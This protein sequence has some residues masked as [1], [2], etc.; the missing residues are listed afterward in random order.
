MKTSEPLAPTA[1]P[2]RDAA[3][4]RETHL[5][6]LVREHEKALLA[7]TEKLLNDHYL[8]EDI[9]QETLVRAWHNA[10]RL[11][12]SEGSVRGWLLTVARNLV[13]DRSRSGFHR[14]EVTGA[15]MFDV[16]QR[17]HADAVVASVTVAEML[18]SLSAEHRDV[19]VHTYLRGRTIREAADDLGIPV[20]TAKSRQHYALSHL[21]KYA[22]AKWLK[23]R[24]A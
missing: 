9:V 22:R 20:G 13:I 11:V 21:K 14:H 6:L 2:Q 7:Y 1:G 17:D 5:G 3:H 23:A 10:D 4:R 24:A 16:T 12:D 18:G 15:E 19:L 8:A